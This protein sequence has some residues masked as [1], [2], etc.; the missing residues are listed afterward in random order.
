MSFVLT[1]PLIQR[2]RQ[3]RRP[4]VPEAVKAC[5]LKN[6]VKKKLRDA[7]ALEELCATIFRSE[8]TAEYCAA[9]NQ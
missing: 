1:R 3:S 8:I 2:D 6:H 7:S 4:S 9:T 5:S